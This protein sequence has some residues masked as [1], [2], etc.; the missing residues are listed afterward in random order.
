MK[1]LIIIGNGFD[2]AHNLKTDYRSFIKHIVDTHLQDKTKYNHLLYLGENYFRSFEDLI[3]LFKEN[4][5]TRVALKSSGS[6]IKN[7]FLL[8]LLMDVSLQNWV[9]IESKYF[10]ILLSIKDGKQNNISIENF[11][12]NFL[13]IKQILEDYLFSEEKNYKPVQSYQT[14]FKAISNLDSLVLNF[15]YTNTVKKY[16]NGSN[17]KKIQIHGELNNIEN[18]I[19]FGYAANDSESRG[20]INTGNNEFSRYIKKQCYKRTTS[21]RQLRDYLNKGEFNVLILGHSCGLSDKLILNQIF[22]NNNLKTIRVFYYQE[23]ED[24]FNK[25][26]NI[27]R[28]MQSEVNLI[29]LKEFGDNQSTRMPQYNDKEEQFV[30]FNNFINSIR[31]ELTPKKRIS[32]V[33]YN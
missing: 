2:L 22:N 31:K 3:L 27:D 28:I 10:Q 29:K 20:L 13:E 25:Q 24:Y 9:D 4:N 21:E 19:I 5:D 15:N 18:P 6:M 26:V 32:S 8:R 30:N 16:I 17:L 12:Q 1:N 14:F 11:N 7:Y 23:Y 33:S